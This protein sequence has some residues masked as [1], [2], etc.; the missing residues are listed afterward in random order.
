MNLLDCRGCQDGPGR[1]GL[2]TQG[3]RL[4]GFRAITSHHKSSP[5]RPMK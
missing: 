3:K 1:R 2:G 4:Y 5:G